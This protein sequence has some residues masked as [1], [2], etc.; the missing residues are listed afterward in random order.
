MSNKNRILKITTGILFFLFVFLMIWVKFL[1]GSIV[2]EEPGVRYT[3]VPGASMKSVVHDLYSLNL[4]KHPFLFNALIYLKGNEQ[5]LKAGDYIFLKDTTPSSLLTQITSGTGMFHY[6]FT[7]IAG[8]NFKHLRDILEHEPNLQHDSA[9]MTDAAIM[10]YLKQPALSPEGRFY[11]DTYYFAKGSSDLLLLKRAFQKMQTTLDH[12][13]KNRDPGLP[14]QTQN[15]ILTVASLVE[16]ETALNKER[17]LIA[18]VI[19]NRLRKNMLLQMDPTIIYATGSHYNG[20]IYKT[21][22]QVESPYNTYKYRG[23][24]P[25]PI[26]IP[27]QES[28]SA[29][30]HPEHHDY[31]Y[32]V[33]K[34]HLKEEGHQFSATLNEHNAAVINARENQIYFNDSLVRSY[35]L[36]TV[37]PEIYNYF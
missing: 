28:I 19:V 14:Y 30:L 2:P 13:W 5:E 10:A 24:P 29:A 36:K 16:K 11:P 34:S 3:V 18:G 8:W 31:Y 21:D 33:A 6:T 4:I 23:L 22:M 9:S 1:Y 7:I 32:F 37:S 25:T 27:S 17:P 12:A 35:F 26:A 15:D 20:T